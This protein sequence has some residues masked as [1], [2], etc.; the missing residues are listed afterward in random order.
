[1]IL[2]PDDTRRARDTVRRNEA[3]GQ[4]VATQNQW[5]FAPVVQTAAVCVV[6][7]TSVTP[8]TLSGGDKIYPAVITR[9]YETT[10][11][12]T[13]EV[14]YY[15]PANGETPALNAR[16]DAVC[17]GQYTP[18]RGSIFCSVVP[19]ASTFSG[20]KC[21]QS[22]ASNTMTSGSIH[23]LVFDVEQF[24]T[25]AYHP[26]GSSGNFVVPSAGYYH[27]GASCSW[28]PFAGLG[29]NSL[30]FLTVNKNGSYT[31]NAAV[32]M[33]DGPILFVSDLIHCA[34]S[35]TITFS[36]EQDTGVSW[37]ANAIAWVY[38]VG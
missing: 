3:Q 17:V 32:D 10:S 1:M 11:F 15:L 12:Q 2:H 31:N 38:K 20:V 7:V 25:D 19:A 35:D 26:A 37:F 28:V 30:V 16:Y 4:V 14:C 13:E 23:T 9:W 24:D 22:S 6:K 34:A 5:D 27:A 21:A 29:A 33:G 18:D 8:V 36:V